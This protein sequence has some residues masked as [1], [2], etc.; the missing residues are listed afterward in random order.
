ML[1]AGITVTAELVVVDDVVSP[2]P[3]L[4]VTVIVLASDFSG[5]FPLG[6]DTGSQSVSESL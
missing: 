3:P 2:L 1:A 5:V 4:A 6:G